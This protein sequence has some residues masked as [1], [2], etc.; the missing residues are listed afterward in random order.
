M[1]SVDEWKNH[2]AVSLNH[3]LS[4][5]ELSPGEY[6]LGVGMYDLSTGERLKITRGIF[7]GN[8][9]LLLDNFILE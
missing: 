4:I 5:S 3:S 7:A 9:W 2:T 8:D 6:K 1:R